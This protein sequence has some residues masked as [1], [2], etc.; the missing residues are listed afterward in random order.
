MALP[1][2]HVFSHHDAIDLTALLVTVLLELSS[3]GWVAY[4][5]PFVSDCNRLIRQCQVTGGG[6]IRPREHHLSTQYG[7]ESNHQPC[8]LD[9][10]LPHCELLGYGP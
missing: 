10:R 7:H 4:S 9:L 5:R 6:I 3:C 2:P 1:A 8:A